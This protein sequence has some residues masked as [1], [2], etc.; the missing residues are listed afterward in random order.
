MAQMAPRPVK[1]VP[2]LLLTLGFLMDPQFS[3]SW[4][5]SPIYVVKKCA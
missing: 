3:A 1:E 4:S 2:I 5:T